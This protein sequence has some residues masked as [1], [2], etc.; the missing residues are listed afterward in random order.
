MHAQ[1]TIEVSTFLVNIKHYKLNLVFSKIEK[2]EAIIQVV[3]VGKN[4]KRIFKFACCFHGTYSFQ[5]FGSKERK[6]HFI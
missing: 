2:V 5:A 1:T 6:F 3:E 4:V